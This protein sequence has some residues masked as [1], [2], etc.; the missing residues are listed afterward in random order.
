[1]TYFELVVMK[2][3][4]GKPSIENKEVANLSISRPTWK[5]F[6]YRS[7]ILQVSS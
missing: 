7:T 6:S 5:I 4:F 1:M 2:E 3:K